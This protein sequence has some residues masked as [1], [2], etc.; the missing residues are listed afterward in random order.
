[1]KGSQ[2]FSVCPRLMGVPSND[3]HLGLGVFDADGATVRGEQIGA[4]QRSHGRARAFRVLELDKRYWGRRVAGGG[5]RSATRRRRRRR[6]R[7]ACSG[8]AVVLIAVHRPRVHSQAGESRQT[9]R[10]CCVVHRYECKGL[11]IRCADRQAGR[12]AGAAHQGTIS[13]STP[14]VVDVDVVQGCW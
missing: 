2:Y 10:W 4:L 7:H 5:L 11:I 14:S 6:G 1:M 12:R 3:G 8:G 9:G 13:Q